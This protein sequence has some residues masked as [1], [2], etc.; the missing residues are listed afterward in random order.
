ML[1]YWYLEKHNEVYTL[2]RKVIKVSY[3]G[4]INNYEVIICNL[5]LCKLVY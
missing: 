5:M 1:I 4:I 3:K 2:S